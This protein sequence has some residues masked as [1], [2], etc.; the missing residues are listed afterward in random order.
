V[1]ASA[2]DTVVTD[3][4]FETPEIVAGERAVVS[5]TVA[6][7]QSVEDT[8]T[9]RLELFGEVVNTRAVTVAGGGTTTV[10]FTHEIVAPGEYTATVDSE[11]ATVRVR[12]AG[13]TTSTAAETTSTEFPG[14]GAVTTLLAVV[15][16]VALA[17]GRD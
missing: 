9:V 10:Q 3:V 8:H 1:A 6:N 15:L 5:V 16:A 2:D 17:A 12:P 14:L 4:S 13:T 11:S 7:P